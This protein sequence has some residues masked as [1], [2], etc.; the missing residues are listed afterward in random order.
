MARITSVDC[1][2]EPAMRMVASWCSMLMMT[3]WICDWLR[4]S[5]LTV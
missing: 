1:W 2:M 4:Y 3:D 5:L